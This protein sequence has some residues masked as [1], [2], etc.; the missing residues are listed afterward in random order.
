MRVPRTD[1]CLTEQN[2]SV[3]RLP[4]TEGTTNPITEDPQST[5]RE[6]NSLWGRARQDRKESPFPTL[7]SSLLFIRLTL[8]QINQI[9]K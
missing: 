7:P 9:L 5:N 3:E 4:G 2:Y 6:V 1:S 8:N